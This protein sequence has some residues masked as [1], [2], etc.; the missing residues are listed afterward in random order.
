MRA[1]AR[2]AAVLASLAP[3]APL[4]GCAG[5]EAVWSHWSPERLRAIDRAGFDA[6]TEDLV[7]GGH[8]VEG[9]TEQAVRL[10]WGPPTWTRSVRED[11]AVWTTYDYRCG[12]QVMFRDGAVYAVIH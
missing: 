5:P 8:V 3:F 2:W 12:A 7:R 6:R 1:A 10:A 9:M 11:G 4:T